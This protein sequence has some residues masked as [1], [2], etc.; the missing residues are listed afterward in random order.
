MIENESSS[1]PIPIRRRPFSTG[2]RI[3]VV[4]VLVLVALLFSL[5]ALANF[6]TD[7]LWFDSVDFGG[8]W[9][10]L[11]F[12]KIVLGVIGI[13]VA[14]GLMFGNLWLAGGVGPA[15]GQP[16]PGEAIGLPPR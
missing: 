10:T 9:R 3:A 12:T 6:W 16:G 13:A 5:R 1:G 7:Y 15:L 14:F 11:L 4:V 2:R 8:V